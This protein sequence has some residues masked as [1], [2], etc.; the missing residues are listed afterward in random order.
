[1]DC[2]FVTHEKMLGAL[3]ASGE[4]RDFERHENYVVVIPELTGTFLQ[5][6]RTLRRFVEN[7]LETN[8][9]LHFVMY[10]PLAHRLPNPTI[11]SDPLSSLS[12]NPWREKLIVN[13]R[14]FFADA[15]DILD[16]SRARGLQKK[17]F[18][19]RRKIN[20]TSGTFVDFDRFG[21]AAMKEKK[22]WFVF[23]GRF[24]PVKQVT[25]FARAIPAICQTIKELGLNDCKFFI[26][27][28]GKLEA[29]L[30][31]IISRPEFADVDVEMRYE[32]APNEI[33]AQAKVF[34]S[35]QKF[36]NYP[37]KSLA[38]AL[39]SGC[40]P[41]VT[42]CGTTRRMAQPEFSFYV[43]EAFDA[44][45]LCAK[46]K[47]IFELT[48]EERQNKSNA[49]VEFARN[50]LTIDKMTDYYLDLYRMLYKNQS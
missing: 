39:A 45:A 21:A 37:S 5:K 25:E 24:E 12:G 1:M 35:L 31:E 28:H 10:Y 41:V 13:A 29:E 32:P 27:G 23:L 38:E 8:E 17:Y 20:L 36:T 3:R 48:D 33:M 7:N 26:L 44:G 42:D 4:F 50:N 9:I 2:R 34:F 30:R 16:P 22:N 40:L 47:E 43:P 46:I 49:A 11:F 15:A 6:S 19:N 14:I 18:W